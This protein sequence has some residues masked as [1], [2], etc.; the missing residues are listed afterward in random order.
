MD[1]IKEDSINVQK[2]NWVRSGYSKYLVYCIR[3]WSLKNSSSN[4][5]FRKKSQ[6]WRCA[7]TQYGVICKTTSQRFPLKF[8]KKYALKWAN[9]G[10]Y[11]NVCVVWRDGISRQIYVRYLASIRIF[12]ICRQITLC[13]SRSL[14]LSFFISSF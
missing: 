4:F 5:V 8:H 13:K 10:S 9:V 14:A 3:F 1:S 11:P 2:V 12:L 7:H 6:T